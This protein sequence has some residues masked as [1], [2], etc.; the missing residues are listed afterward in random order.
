[1]KVGRATPQKA[2]RDQRDL[3]VEG[4]SGG[5]SRGHGS[6]NGVWVGWKLGVKRRVIHV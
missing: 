1:M 4:G 5:V 2:E 6:G 3:I